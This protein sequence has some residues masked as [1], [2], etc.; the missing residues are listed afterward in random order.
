MAKKITARDRWA[1][2]AGS[3]FSDHTMRSSVRNS[4]SKRFLSSGTKSALGGVRVD[5]LL[6]PSAW[7]GSAKKIPWRVAFV[8]FT[9]RS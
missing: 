1:C 6:E 4:A 7:A 9:H 2:T 8:S 3:S 5:T